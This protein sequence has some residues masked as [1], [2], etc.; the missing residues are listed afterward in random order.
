MLDA[1]VLP[2]LP[3]LASGAAGE[4]IPLAHL[5]G[6]LTGVG[7]VLDGDGR[8]VA[9]G[10]ALRSAGIAPYH[11]GAKEGIALIEGVPVTTALA[12]LRAD[13]ARQAPCATPSWCSPPSSR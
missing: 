3:R 4:I 1:G 11:L 5:G 6:A 2:A 13:E 8:A 7:Q 9:A 10:P 12:L